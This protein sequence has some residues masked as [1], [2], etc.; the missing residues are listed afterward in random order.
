MFGGLEHVDHELDLLIDSHVVVATSEKLDLLM[1][2][3]PE[4][5]ERIA[6][7]IVDEGHLIGDKARGLRL[8]LMLTR[9]RRRAPSARLLLTSAVVPNSDGLGGWLLPT[10]P[11]RSVSNSSWS[12]SRLRVGVFGWQGAERHGR[13]GTVRYR[14]D[15]ADPNFFV[16]RV[17]T[18]HVPPTGRHPFPRDKKDIAAA[19]VL[20]Y[21]RLGPVLVGSTTRPNVESVAKAL[22]VAHR[23]RRGITRIAAF[24]AAVEEEATGERR[25]LADLVD[26]VA[27][28]G[29]QLRQMVL[30]GI[31]YHHAGLPDRLRKAFEQAYR[32]GRRDRRTRCPGGQHRRRT[33]APGE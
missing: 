10:D 26:E 12:P 24:A 25:K 11:E 9:L 19:L 14:P 33:D 31:A 4:F 16:P 21:Q 6:L 8:E 1:R 27:G 18:Q 17:L 5:A 13:T 3:S 23:R 32:D 22:V 7:V 15:D 2:N 28:A 29:H 30:L 20:H